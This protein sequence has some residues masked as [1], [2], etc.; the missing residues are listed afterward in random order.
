MGFPE[1]VTE[2]A[3]PNV[4]A[5]GR[6]WWRFIAMWSRL[7]RYRAVADGHSWVDAL[8]NDA[9]VDEL[10]RSFGFRRIRVRW[11][12]RPGF[13]FAELVANCVVRCCLCYCDREKLARSPVFR[14]ATMLQRRYDS[15]FRRATDRDDVVVDTSGLEKPLEWRRSDF[16]GLQER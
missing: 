7:D 3:V 9:A 8:R 12:S 14:S 2:A 13:R 15:E 10:T 1:F 11:C 6:R 16:A 5:G 4:K